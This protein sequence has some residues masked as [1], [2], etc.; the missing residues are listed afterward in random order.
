MKT[1]ILHVCIC[2]LTIWT[3]LIDG[4]NAVYGQ[5]GTQPQFSNPIWATGGADPW[6]YQEG[7]LYYFTYTQGSKIVI[8]RT[9][10]ITHLGDVVASQPAY[11]TVYT[12]PAE[13]KNIWAPE[14]HKINGKWYVYFAA[15]DGDNANHRMYVIEN[16]DSDPTSTNWTLKG[17]VK[18][19]TDNWAIDGTVTELNGQLYM[20][21]SG[22]TSS[23]EHVQ[24]IYIAELSDP[25]TVS[26]NR[27]MISTPQYDWEK[28]GLALNEGPEFLKNAAGNV[29]VTFSA[30]LYATDNYCLGLL[31][32]TPGANPM[33]AASWTKKSEPVFTRND[34]GEVYGP[35]HNGFFKSPDGTE[36]WI[37]YHARSKADGGSDN[38]RNVR[39]QQFTWNAD[40]SPN[41]G[42]AAAVGQLLNAPSS[43]YNLPVGAFSTIWKSDMG[44]ANASNISFEATGSNFD[45]HWQYLDVPSV[46]GN[47]SGVN[48]NNSL[49]FPAPGSYLVSITPGAGSF[50][51]FKV[52]TGT[53]NK[54]LSV[55]QWGSPVW[56][57]FNSAFKG[58]AN[59]EIHAVDKPDLSNCSDMS[60]AFYNCSAL[61]ENT[62]MGDWNVSA[63]TNLGSTFRGASAFNQNI[64]NWDVSNVTRLDFAFYGCKSFNQPME[65]WNVS[66]V[67]NMS[68]LFF[69]CVLFNQPIGTWDVSQV[70]NIGHVVQGAHA[71]NQDISGWNVSNV[72]NMAYMFYDASSFNQDITGWDVSN[73]TNMVRLLENASAF[74]QNLGKWD[75]R[76]VAKANK[77]DGS[78]VNALN[79]TAISCSNYSLILKGWDENPNTPSGL[80]LTANGLSYDDT[81]ATG[82]HND[83]VTNKSWVI[84]GD[85]VGSCTVNASSVPVTLADFSGHI[86]RGQATLNWQSGVEINVDHYELE[87]IYNESGKDPQGSF[88][89][90]GSLNAKG[91]GNT[92]KMTVT[93]S[94]E[95]AYYRLKIVDQ[96]G[97]ISYSPKLVQ[98]NQKVDDQLKLY[99]NPAS[100]NITVQ[101]NKPGE[102]R[103]YTTAGVLVK[104][105]TLQTGR[106]TINISRLSAGVYFA[107]IDNQKIKLIKR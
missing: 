106:N 43:D 8:Y 104:K 6:I 53:P 86:L 63:V 105:V 34:A 62:A 65:N 3:G 73:V 84:S 69:G 48:G 29:F 7:G 57:T 94:A 93:Q 42:T 12:P 30:S 77:G 32:L 64:E 2:L 88:V 49:T 4:G 89:S 35:G 44:D 40:G 21:W 83:L 78:L 38:P 92:Y 14:L 31:T 27:V 19:A 95:N 103:F 51:A 25:W 56:S 107:E 97:T 80:T 67:T 101:I 76:S 37:V 15:D 13:M 72:T 79:N 91:N 20:L 9:G 74:N 11:A 82:Y 55:E 60:S 59:M 47:Q 96:D 16:P 41:F 102:L 1:R 68:N 17:Q 28:H 33:L 50:T 36:D 61:T 100:N 45:I 23:T 22:W 70:T 10:D 26:S 81:Y 24:S 98:L 54:L 99:P 5:G 75:I 46:T 66:S 58:A 18:D 39:I 85:A 87:V 90:L 52:G 71:F